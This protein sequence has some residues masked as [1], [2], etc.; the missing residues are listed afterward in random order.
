MKDYLIKT[1]LEYRNIHDEDRQT[2][3]NAFT[4]KHYK[5]GQW[6]IKAGQVAHH[7]FY[8]NSGVLKITIPHPAERDIVYYFMEEHQFMTFLYSLGGNVPTQQGLQ[9]ATDA[10]IL[11]INNYD[12]NILYKRLPYLKAT[13][14]DMAQL[15]M[16]N[17]VTM[18]NNFLVGEALQKYTFFLNKQLKIAQQVALV[19]VASYLGITPQSLSRVR[20]K[21][22]SNK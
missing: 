3:A 18:K 13:I 12:L 2:I 9:A 7:L 8:I 21:F 1:L 5:S 14:D 6:L 22:V 10:D 20:K 16:A 19:D 15:S 11:E 4:L 17:M